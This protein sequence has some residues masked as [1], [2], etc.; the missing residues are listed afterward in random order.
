[1]RIALNALKSIPHTVL[2]DCSDLH[3]SLP[4][5]RKNQPSYVNTVALIDTR[6]SPFLLLEYCQSIEKKQGRVQKIKWG[7][8]IIDIDILSYGK[9][10]INNPR[11]TLPHIFMEIRE[12]VQVP[13]KN[14]TKKSPYL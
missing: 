10:K 12:F 7:A 2:L 13:L 5:G 3:F 14:L 8:R 4:W 11:L 9:K 1:M 6:L